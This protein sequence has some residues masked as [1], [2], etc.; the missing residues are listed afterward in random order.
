MRRA[1]YACLLLLL[2]SCYSSPTMSEVDGAN[3]IEG[4]LAPHGCDGSRVP[5]VIYLGN[6]SSWSAC[7]E[8]CLRYNNG[9]ARCNSATWHHPDFHGGLPGRPCASHCY[10]RTDLGWKP[11]KEA[12]ITSGKRSDLPPAMINSGTP[13]GVPASFDCA[14][15]KLSWQ[16]GKKLVPSQGSFAELF[17][18]V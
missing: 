14:I 16:Y 7:A 17:E 2:G 8:A 4:M 10:G 3:N 6:Q 5:P 18:A 15:R 1:R 11:Q 9:S 13:L 12:K